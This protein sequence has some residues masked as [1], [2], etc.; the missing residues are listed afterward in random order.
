MTA[1][2]IAAILSINF[3]GGCKAPSTSYP[4]GNTVAQVFSG[5]AGNGWR[6]N[7]YDARSQD[8]MDT[9]SVT[10]DNTTTT[11]TVS[12]S[13]NNA[14]ELQTLTYPDGEI[15]SYNNNDDGYFHGLTTANGNIVSSVN[16]TLFGA[17]ASMLIGGAAYKGNS[18]LQYK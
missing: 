2:T 11:Q 6:C 18:R 15:V 9:L 10:S 8:I 13:Y 1:I 3:P 7:G 14:G 16:Y 4:I 12:K 17:V 5:S